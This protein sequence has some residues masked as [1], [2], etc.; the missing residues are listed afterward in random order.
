M[1]VW[2]WII[3]ALFSIFAIIPVIKLDEVRSNPQ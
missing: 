1:N 3:Y 2:I